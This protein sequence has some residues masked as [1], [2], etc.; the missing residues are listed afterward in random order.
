MTARRARST[1]RTSFTGQLC[2]RPVAAILCILALTAIYRPAGAQPQS[3]VVAD[4]WLQSQAEAGLDALYGMQYARA[5]SIF[6]VIETR[7]PDHPIAPFLQ[8]LVTWW[9]ILPSLTVHDTS[10]DRDFLRQMDRVIRRSDR[11]LRSDRHSFDGHFFKGA[12]HGFRGRLHSDRESWLRA[13]QDGRAALDH[14]FA[15]A[16]E[17]TS[18]ADAVFGV[19]V[20]DYFA[21][22]IPEKYP[23]VRPLMIF[24]PDANKE[25]GLQRLQRVVDEGRFIR[26]E[27]AWFLLQIYLVFD[28]NYDRSRHYVQWLRHH[29]PDNALFHLM[30]GRVFIKWG[31]WSPSSDI[32]REVV[33]A[34]ESGRPGYTAPL[35]AQAQYFLGRDAMNSHRYDEALSHFAEVSRLEA[36]FEHASYAR[37]HAALRTG[38]IYDV[39]GQR[40]RA[41]RQYR[42]VLDWSD[43]G[44]SHERARRY[45]K[46]P[47]RGD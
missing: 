32:F 13:A 5:D 44:S 16:E 38:M 2:I 42:Q 23:I 40:E 15:V 12:A 45:L 25:R 28:P 7:Y 19:G 31:Q 37:I 29:H 3:S 1:Q 14:V 20:Y 18:W 27:A 36:R 39:T 33:Q 41:R 22:A 8:S 10:Y 17:D 26:T 46:D 9:K 11:L 35:V 24:F 47:Y 6:A 4:P 30:E 34:Y 43:E 21:A